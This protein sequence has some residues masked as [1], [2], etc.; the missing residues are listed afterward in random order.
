MTTDK[1]AAELMTMVR[2]AVTY[3]ISGNQSKMG[4][5]L[6]SIE[7]AIAAKD[8]EREAAVKAVAYAEVK[9]QEVIGTLERLADLL[10]DSQNMLVR[11]T[12]AVSVLN[13]AI[14]ELARIAPM[15]DLTREAQP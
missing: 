2:N 6:N 12:S 9:A 3:G 1:T 7:L 8:A 14:V 15:P 11:H 5:V 4:Q 10:A 13:D